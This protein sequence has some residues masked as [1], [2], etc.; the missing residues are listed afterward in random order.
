VG[1][2]LSGT[3]F[4]ER[5]ASLLSKPAL[6]LDSRSHFGGNLYDYKDAQ[7]GVLMNKYGAHLFHTNSNKAYKYVTLAGKGAPKWVRWDH[8]VVGE[9]D[10]LI[11]PIP[12]NANTVNRLFNAGIKT[13][14]E[15]EQW[16]KSVQVPCE[17]G[18]GGEGGECGNAEEM[19]KS[20]VGQGLFEKIFADYTMKQWNK[21]ASALDA[22]VTARIPVRSNFDDR[23]FGDRYQLLPEKGYTQWF[24]S[25]LDHPLIDVVLE[26]D[27]FDVKDELDGMC[28]KIVYT[29]PI[30]RYFASSGYDKLEYRGIDFTVTRYMTKGY[31][32]VNSVVNFPGK[33][34]DYTRIVE[35]KHFLK[36]DDAPGTVLVSE[37]SKDMGPN[38]DPYYPVP[39]PRNMELYAKYQRLAEELEESSGGKIHFV[40]R[41]ANYKYFNMDATIVNALDMFW[42]VA[43]VPNGLTEMVDMPG[44]FGENAAEEEEGGDGFVKREKSSRK[45]TDAAK[46]KDGLA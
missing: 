42:E 34:V 5:Y 12:V 26:T 16:L 24:A 39:N 19:A 31:K 23:Y 8:K 10:G 21:P 37:I 4:A 18:E 43:G 1:A 45:G 2:G 6:V 44:L 29:G 30:D 13:D 20:R 11:V 46:E 32:L 9:I 28:D 40:G 36:Q 3:I 14:E 27:Y 33:E 35:Y 7:T 22:S 38:D 41:L 17:G 25:V 15:M